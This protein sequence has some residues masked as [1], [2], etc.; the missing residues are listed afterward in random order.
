MSF[1][2]W[3]TQN[4][5][6]Y[7]RLGHT[8]AV[9]QDNHLSWPAVLCLIHP[10]HSWP[11]WLPRHTADSYSICHQP[12]LPYLFLQDWSQPLVIQFACITRITCTRCR[13]QHL[14]LLNFIRSVISQLSSLSK[15]LCKASLPLR[16]STV[17]S[18]LGSSANLFNVHSTPSSKS[19][20]QV[21]LQII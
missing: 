5:A 19:L 11:F 20:V 7:S 21:V 9:W 4:F 10:G 1:L 3:G 2:Y 15:S 12:R 14:L 13:I 18:D 16:E 17:P 6:E 8:S